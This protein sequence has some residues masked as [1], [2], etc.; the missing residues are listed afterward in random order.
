MAELVRLTKKYRHK[1]LKYKAALHLLQ[2]ALNYDLQKCFKIVSKIG[3]SDLCNQ[4]GKMVSILS[5]KS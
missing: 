4:I 5:H 3:Y 2:T 1:H